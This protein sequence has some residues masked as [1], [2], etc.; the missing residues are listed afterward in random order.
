M[1]NHKNVSSQEGK[2]RIQ[3]TFGV[4]AQEKRRFR[5][6][7]ERLN[8]KMPNGLKVTSKQ[9]FMVMLETTEESL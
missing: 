3:L 5:Q 9:V 7:K 2:E 4:T 8:E 6:L 1:K